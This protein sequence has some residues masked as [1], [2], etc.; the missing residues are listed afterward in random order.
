M[1]EDLFGSYEKDFCQHMEMLEK[2][3]EAG[4]DSMGNLDRIYDDSSKLL[5]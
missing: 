5:K 3:K 2:I 4:S 1:V